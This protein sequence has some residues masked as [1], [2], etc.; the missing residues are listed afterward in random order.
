MKLSLVTSAEINTLFKEMAALGGQPT[1]EG[2]A[3]QFT[4]LLYK[5]FEDSLVLTRLFATIPMGRLP[6]FNQDFV[7]KLA[8]SA[9]IS[10]Q[11]NEDT[12]TL[13]LL[14]TSGERVEWNNRRSSSAH[15]GIPLASGT[16]VESIP[17]ISRLL[18][19]IGLDLGWLDDWDTKIVSK[20]FLSQSTG[21]FYVEDAKTTEDHHLR[22]IITAQDFVGLYGVKTVFGFGIGFVESPTLAVLVAFAR[23][24]VDQSLVRSLIP[25]MGG[26]KRAAMDPIVKGNFFA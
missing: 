26:F 16:F 13:S 9:G 21:M 1:V 5:R 8:I 19:E 24:T 2:A 7:N 10:K 22:K 15:V 25:V 3:Q 6:R 17:M 14:G 23:E 11:V 20:G 12:M 18:K 4:E